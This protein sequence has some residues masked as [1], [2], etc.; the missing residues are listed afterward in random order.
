MGR[1][2]PSTADAVR[3]AFRNSTLGGSN[4]AARAAYNKEFSTNS[5]AGNA[6]STEAIVGPPKRRG[7]LQ[8]IGD[9]AKGL[10]AFFN[11]LRHPDF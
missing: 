2:Q 9:T 11:K 5:E 1:S 7:Y 4:E 6:M 3:R 8:R 10:G